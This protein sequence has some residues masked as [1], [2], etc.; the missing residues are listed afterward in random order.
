MIDPRN[1]LIKAR[2]YLAWAADEI[3][4]LTENKDNFRV[5]NNDLDSAIKKIRKAEKI[6]LSMET[7]E[8]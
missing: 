6:L 1:E 7:K 8:P 5:T 4:C 3:D 2:E